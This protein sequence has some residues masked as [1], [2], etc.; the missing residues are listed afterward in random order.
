MA[1]D[2]TPTP[3]TSGGYTFF[4]D[5]AVLL[6][7][8]SRAAASDASQEANIVTKILAQLDIAR[9]RRLKS[10][11]KALLA[12][13]EALEGLAALIVRWPEL[14]PDEVANVRPAQVRKLF[15]LQREVEELLVQKV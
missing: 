2:E 14:T 13:A 12:K 9:S 8:R 7:R 5:A 4:H 6:A 3:R 1:D 10:R 15:E 11:A